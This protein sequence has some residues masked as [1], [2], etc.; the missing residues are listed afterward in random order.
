VSKT[1]T[2]L[3]SLTRYY[4]TGDSTNTAYSDAD[5]L[6]N[7]NTRY[8][9]AFLLATQNDGD[10]EFNGD[11]S[12]SINIVAGTRA[13]DLATDLFK[14]S[15]VEIKYPAAATD[16]Q[17]ANP[18]DGSQIQY[19]GKD[20][21]L[22]SL[23]EIDLLA[24][25][26][27]IFVSQKTANIEAV[28]AGIKVYYQKS[29]TEL[30]SGSDTTIFPDVFARYIA[31]G[32]AIDYCGVNGL[33]GRLSWLNNELQKQSDMLTLYIVDR[34]KAKRLSLRPRKENYGAG[35]NEGTY[36]ISDKRIF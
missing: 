14:V 17:R 6:L 12:Q 2:N 34:N 33:G 23:P 32:A 3:R 1:L 26:V 36:G 25:K 7:L 30:V 29:L 16:Y 10:F 20:N 35:Y 11:G 4:A 9:E 24:G 5:T 27:E 15:R 8:Q 21:Y 18:I 19:Y 22:P 31:L 28:S 13:Y